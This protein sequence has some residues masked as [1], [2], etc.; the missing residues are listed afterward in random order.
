[1]TLMEEIFFCILR[2]GIRVEIFLFPVD[3]HADNH[4]LMN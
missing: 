1:M 4:G 2:R 3:L